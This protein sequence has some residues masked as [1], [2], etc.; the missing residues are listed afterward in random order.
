MLS[1]TVVHRAEATVWGAVFFLLGVL[2]KR[3]M[4]MLYSLSVM[5]ALQAREYLRARWL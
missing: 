2:A 3:K 4:A 5:S 1:M